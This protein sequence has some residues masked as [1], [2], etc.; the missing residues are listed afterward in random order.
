[1]SEYSNLSDVVPSHFSVVRHNPTDYEQFREFYEGLSDKLA[2]FEEQKHHEEKRERL[3]IWL[4]RAGDTWRDAKLSR[5]SNDTVQPIRDSVRERGATSFFLAGPS[6]SGKTFTAYAIIRSYVVSG[7]VNPTRALIVSE[8][9]LLDLANSGFAGRDELQKMLNAP[10]DVI[11]IDDI[12]S[13]SRYSNNE[14]AAMERLIDHAHDQAIPLIVTSLLSPST[15]AN[16][17][18]QSIN[19][20]LRDLYPS[21]DS[22]I[23]L[24]RRTQDTWGNDHADEHMDN[25]TQSVLDQF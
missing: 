13:V 19:S 12:G 7:Y 1:M 24:E 2:D 4:Q 20:T 8:N 25:G 21:Q 22:V 3:R 15:W 6:P 9:Y 23:Q 10:L 18:R 16:M 14:S 5:V 11:L 17:M